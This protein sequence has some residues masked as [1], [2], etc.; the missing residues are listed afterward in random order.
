[1]GEPWFVKLRPL[2][3]EACLAAGSTYAVEVVLF[4]LARWCQKRSKKDRPDLSVLEVGELERVVEQIVRNLEGDGSRVEAIVAGDAEALAALRRVLLASAASRSSESAHELADE[5]LQ[6]IALILLT[7]TPPSRAAQRLDEG[8]EGPG[9][10]YV[11]QSPFTFWSRLVVI[12]LAV[13]VHRREA[14]ERRFPAERPS[15]RVKRF[16][17]AILH[18][19]MEAL[20]S[21]LAAIRALPHVQRSIMVLS[22]SRGDIEEVVRERLHELAPDLFS[23]VDPPTSDRQIAERLGTTPKLVAASRSAA[24]VKLVARDARWAL[25]LDALLPHRS[26]RPA[27][28]RRRRGTVR[29]GPPS[30]PEAS[31]G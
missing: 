18:A 26:T 16:D 28:A 1:M 3:K 9:N 8:P 12:N 21:L 24:R 5:A 15:G 22:L 2:C 31:D 6:K 14:R 27:R 7:G 17:R 10:E 13:D 25:L 30:R 4:Y 11:F 29:T 20:P 23:T 19:A